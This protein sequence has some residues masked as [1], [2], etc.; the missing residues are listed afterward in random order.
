[1]GLDPAIYDRFCRIRAST[2][3]IIFLN[4]RKQHVTFYRRY[5]SF[6]IVTVI[7]TLGNLLAR[8]WSGLDETGPQEVEMIIEAP[9][10]KL[11]SNFSFSNT[12]KTFRVLK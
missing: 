7:A 10:W 6:R 8:N 11:P 12:K 1:M 2:V 9:N 4:I 3:E 5:C